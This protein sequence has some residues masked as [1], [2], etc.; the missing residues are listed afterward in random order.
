[1]EVIL[2]IPA[3]FSQILPCFIR[4]EME[5]TYQLSQISFSCKWTYM[6]YILNLAS[7]D[8]NLV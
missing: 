3:T 5:C 7:N 1:M 6:A 4:E 8:E 2:A